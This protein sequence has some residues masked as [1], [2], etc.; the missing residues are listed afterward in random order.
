M[1]MVVLLALVQ[2]ASN[3]VTRRRA[4]AALI[5]DKIVVDMDTTTKTH[6]DAM[7]MACYT[8]LWAKVQGIIHG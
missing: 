5:V 8:R 4:D 7:A 6:E 2:L 1:A 3:D